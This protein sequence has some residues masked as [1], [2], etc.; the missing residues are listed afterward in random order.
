M[1]DWMAKVLKGRNFVTLVVVTLMAIGVFG[2]GQL[3]AAENGELVVGTYEPQQVFQQSEGQQELM[4][5]FQEAQGSMQAAQEEGDQQKMQKLQSDMREKQE[6]IIGKFQDE[7]EKVLPEV[8]DATGVDII[9]QG[10]EYTADDIDEKDVTD[11][12]IKA[13]GGDPDSDGGMQGLQPAPE[14][15]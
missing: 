10:V 12:V 15:E 8:A 5:A 11:D 4:E 14:E 1:A 2:T 6:E 3:E 9:A 7:L 13:M